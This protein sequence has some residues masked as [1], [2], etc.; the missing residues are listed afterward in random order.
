MSKFET[1]LEN[2]KYISW[3][4]NKRK[5]ERSFVVLQGEA[6]EGIM[7]QI[8]DSTKGYGKIYVLKVKD[9]PEPIIITGKTDLNNKFGYGTMA[10][11]QVKIGDEVR[12]TF[13]GTYPT[14]TGKTGYKFDVA[15][16]RN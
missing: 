7:E 1:V 8:K 15:V 11:P 9:C 6:V 14:K 10:V 12:I 3:G 4:K 5:D 13:T 16:K 2:V